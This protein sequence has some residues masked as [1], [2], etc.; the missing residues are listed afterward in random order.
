MCPLARAD[1]ALSRSA[2]SRHLD[3]LELDLQRLRGVFHRCQQRRVHRVVARQEN[4]H[5]AQARNGLLENFKPFGVEL[6]DEEARPGDVATRTRQA[7]DGPDRDG[8]ADGPEHDG[9]RV[10]RPLG[11]ERSR[12]P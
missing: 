7:V 10:R 2:G 8:L 1:T 6:Q 4:P 11:G 5:A 12:S 3:G 9:N